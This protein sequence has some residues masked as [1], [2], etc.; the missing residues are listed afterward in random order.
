MLKVI[1]ELQTDKHIRRA[2]FVDPDCVDAYVLGV[3]IGEAVAAIEPNM[4]TPDSVF[5]DRLQEGIMEGLPCHITGI[6][7]DKVE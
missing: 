2:E 4:T 1:L 7:K 3:M 5:L 6:C